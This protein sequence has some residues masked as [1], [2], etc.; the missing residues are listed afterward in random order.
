M[1]G[2]KLMADENQKD[3]QTVDVLHYDGRTPDNY[4][5]EGYESQEAFLQEMREDIKPIWN[6]IESIE[7]KLLMIR[8]SRSVNSGTR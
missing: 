8:N 2:I 3:G 7:N 1:D 6:S 4:I 5:P